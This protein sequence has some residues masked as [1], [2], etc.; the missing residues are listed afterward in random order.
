MLDDVA[1]EIVTVPDPD[2]PKPD[3]T[4]APKP[5]STPVVPEPVV[6]PAPV[7][8][9]PGVVATPSPEPEPPAPPT[10]DS[11]AA[12]TELLGSMVSGS[13]PEKPVA[14]SAPPAVPEAKVVPVTPTRGPKD[15]VTAEKLAELYGDPAVFNA[16]LNQVRSD[17]REEAREEFLLNAPPML[18]HVAR[19]EVA[20]H[21]LALDFFK[22]NPDLAP[23]RQL[24]GLVANA[25]Q[26]KD[27]ALNDEK[28]L[29]ESAKLVRALRSSGSIPAAPATTPV[30]VA[31]P[32]GGKQ[33]GVAPAPGARSAPGVAM[34]PAQ[35]KIAELLDFD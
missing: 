32:R 29:A 12:L 1:P 34:T 35:K 26:S 7:A 28:T 4:A 19:T 31:T 24:I 14:P 8:P 25:M 15:Y 2:L 17:A 33:G 9:K 13:T 27:P 16:L 22:A 6:E 3:V 23:Y 10:V 5:A 30:P 20:R 18:A 21:V 11:L